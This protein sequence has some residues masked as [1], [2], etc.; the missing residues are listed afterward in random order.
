VRKEYHAQYTKWLA[1]VL[2]SPISEEVKQ[3]FLTVGQNLIATPPPY[4]I[5]KTGEQVTH[6]AVIAYCLARACP[7]PFLKQ[8]FS[9]ACVLP[10]DMEVE[11][12]CTRKNGKYG[13]YFCNSHTLPELRK[14][15]LPVAVIDLGIVAS[16][17]MTSSDSLYLQ[18]IGLFGG[19]TSFVY[20]QGL[21]VM[22]DLFLKWCCE[23]IDDLFVNI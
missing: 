1:D 9:G 19:F 10:K 5:T 7:S 20:V 23:V 15:G 13:V 17:G 12:Y 18:L 21:E 8:I 11:K 14:A 3:W 22:E 6:T 4:S 16:S 2:R